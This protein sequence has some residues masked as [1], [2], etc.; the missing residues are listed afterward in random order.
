MADRETIGRNLRNARENRSITQQAAAEHVGLSRT[1]IAQIELGNRPVSPDELA[2]LAELYG[3]SVVDLVGEE[4]PSDD[5]LLLMLFDLAPETLSK[6]AKTRV[7]DILGLC[8]EAAAIEAVLGRGQK[9][10]LPRYEEGRPRTVTEALTQ[11]DRAALEERRR[12]GLGR[13]AVQDLSQLLATQ[14]VRSAVVDLPDDVGGVF[15]QHDSLGIALWVNG[16]HSDLQQR[17]ALA[18]EYSHALLDRDRSIVVTKRGNAG[19]LVEK[20]ANAFAVAFLLPDDGVRQVL[21]SFDKDQGSRRTYVAY[22]ELSDEGIRAEGRTVPGSQAITYADVC[23]LARRFR[24]SYS[25]VV[26]RLR[27]LDVVAETDMKALLGRKC[28]LAAERLLATFESHS[29]GRRSR[30]DGEA[31]DLKFEVVSLAVEGYRRGVV[32]ASRLERVASKLRLPQ[33]SSAKL[34]ELADAAC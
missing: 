4:S 23:T 2:K 18:H 14:G 20:R 21:A 10:T 24:V 32:D 13:S 22:D 27:A 9:P 12:L 26:H 29:T 1:L 3:Q 16:R 11:G 30:S 6:G 5:D 7:S 25:A 28:L 8:R 34:L 19:E 17:H 15:F 33:L 31:L